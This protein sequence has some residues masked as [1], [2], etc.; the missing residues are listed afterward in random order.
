[1]E[2]KICGQIAIQCCSKCIYTVYCSGACQKFDWK[3]HKDKCVKSIP[4]S[5]LSENDPSLY[6]EL[7]PTSPPFILGKKWSN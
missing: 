7:R 1:M 4:R 2:C 6:I 5:T 3:S